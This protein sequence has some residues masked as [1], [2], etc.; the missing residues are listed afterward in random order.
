MQMGF[1]FTTA[2]SIL[3]VMQMALLTMMQILQMPPLGHEALASP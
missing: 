2:A 3:L 1:G